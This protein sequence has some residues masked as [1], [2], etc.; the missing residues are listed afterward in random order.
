MENDLRRKD[1]NPNIYEI[2]TL[3]L[4]LFYYIKLMKF[5]VNSTFSFLCLMMRSKILSRILLSWKTNI[6]PADYS[7]FLYWKDPFH[8]CPSDLQAV[9]L[10]FMF[11][12]P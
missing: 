4:R 9:Q 5:K 8:V 2:Y 11:Y 1:F 3:C 6:G 10:P 7:K 12:D